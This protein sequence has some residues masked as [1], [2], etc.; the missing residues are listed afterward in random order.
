MSY[1]LYYSGCCF[2]ASHEHEVCGVLAFLVRF[3][4][5]S[6]DGWRILFCGETELVFCPGPIYRSVRFQSVSA[7]VVV[8]VYLCAY[9]V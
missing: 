8:Y 7:A 2:P 5:G 1:T 3:G 6:V 4:E 9:A